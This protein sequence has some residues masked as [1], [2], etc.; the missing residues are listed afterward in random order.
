LRSGVRA[1]GRRTLNPFL[2][3]SLKPFDITYKTDNN[4]FNYRVAGVIIQNNKLL[5]MT[6]DGLPYYYLPGG[7][8]QFFE[9]SI[10]AI[11]RELYEELVIYF[12]V[13]NLLWIH[14]NFFTE[15]V[16]KEV[17]HEI[18]FFYKIELTNTIKFPIEDDFTKSEGTQKN[19]FKWANIYD[20]EQYKLVPN[21]IKSELSKQELKFKHII[22]EV[23]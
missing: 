18:C 11:K 12:E 17:F 1:S 14:E 23:S 8:V 6:N 19:Y 3:N 16:S 9:K 15:S 22:E 5:I 13:N 7:R 10:D 20:L 2:E 4:R 21:F